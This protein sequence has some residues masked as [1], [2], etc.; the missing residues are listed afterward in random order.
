MDILVK[1]VETDWRPA[2]A[3]TEKKSQ[4]AIEAAPPLPPPLPSDKPP[5][6]PQPP[7]PPSDEKK[8][9]PNL[10]QPVSQTWINLN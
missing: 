5:L 3:K 2:N 6:P 8:V 1:E 9:F 4:L 10:P 7:Q